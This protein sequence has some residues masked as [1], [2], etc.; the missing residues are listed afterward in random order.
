MTTLCRTYY[1]KSS[2]DFLS[3]AYIVTGDKLIGCKPEFYFTLW[4]A[5]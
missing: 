5:D 4:D 3:A 1:I 2:S